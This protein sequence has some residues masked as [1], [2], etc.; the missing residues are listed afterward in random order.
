MWKNKYRSYKNKNDNFDFLISLLDNCKTKKLALETLKGFTGGLSSPSKMPCHSYNLP[1]IECKTGSKLVKVKGSTCYKC[2]ALKGRYR[3]NNVKDAMYL[4][5]NTIDKQMWTEAMVLEIAIME[6]SGYIRWH[7]SGDVQ[8]VEHLDRIVN[9]AKWLPNI[10]FWLPTR[11]YKIVD[12]YSKSVPSNLAIRFSA[13]M[14]DSIKEV[15]NKELNSITVKD[16]STFKN[17]NLTNANICHATRKDSTHKCE[18]CRACW[19]TNVKT[20]AYLLH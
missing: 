16:E 8:D 15:S 4:R 18:S 1:A 5:F 6:D 2:Y 7:D 14:I 11:E 12:D 17:M 9:I 3:F 20:V 10:K 19:D 13:H